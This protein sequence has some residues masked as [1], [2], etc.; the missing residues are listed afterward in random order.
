MSKVIAIIP[1]VAALVVLHKILQYKEAPMECGIDESDGLDDQGLPLS[2]ADDSGVSG[3]LEIVAETRRELVIDHPLALTGVLQTY[4]WGKIGELSK[5]AQLHGEFDQGT[6][7]AE[8]W[9]GVHPNGQA[10]T[11][12]NGQ[13]TN[14]ADICAASPTQILGPQVQELYGELPF[15]FKV[16]SIGQPLSIQAHPDP[17]LAKV[18]HAA[19]PDHYPDDRHKPEIAIAITYLEYLRGFRSISE[20]S[21]NFKRR[22]PLKKLL[23]PDLAQ[24]LQDYANHD[25]EQLLRDVYQAVM[26]ADADLLETV[27]TEMLSAID[28]EGEVS[29]EDEWFKTL[30]EDY[31]KGDVGMISFYLLNLGRIEKGQAIFTGPG[32]PHAYLAGDIVE[33]MSNSDNTVRGGIT[34]KFIDVENLLSMLTYEQG[35]MPLV[36]TTPL[37]QSKGVRYVTPAPEFVVDLFD[38]DCISEQHSTN[39]GVQLVFCLSGSANLEVSG[40]AFEL[41]PGG[42]LI[43]PAS[44]PDYTLTVNEG[45]MFRVSVAA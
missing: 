15:L 43:I 17:E 13:T 34:P 21:E 36:E 6:P 9:L 25:S 3:D 10:I 32:I 35:Q 29:R 12:L 5:A 40:S 31:P 24:R 16:L 1:Q 22:E 7:Y 14:F 2:G 41:K 38:N 33:V 37:S 45:S 39:Q 19:D 44:C 30:A 11:T 23:G 20:I 27:T 28:V 4:G 26:R 8:L 18:L 42:A